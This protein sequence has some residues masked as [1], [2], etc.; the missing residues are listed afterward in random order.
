MR[1]VQF[2]MMALMMVLFQSNQVFAER[3]DDGGRKSE[4]GTKFPSNDPTYILL[5][6]ESE[7]DLPRTYLLPFEAY[8][9][10]GTLTIGSL[11]DLSDVTITIYKDDVAVYSFVRDFYFMDLHQV[12]VTSYVSGEY[13]LI[14]TTP[15]G[16]Y[17]YGYFQL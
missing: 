2:L 5:G 9:Q 16:T 12:P 10:G 1:K 6:G 13:C 3:T 15:R 4:S 7:K 11:S 17:I 8:I 14:L